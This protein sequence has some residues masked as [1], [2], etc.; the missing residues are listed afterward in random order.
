MDTSDRAPAG[1][2]N[3]TWEILMEKWMYLLP[4]GGAVL[5]LAAASLNL[6]TAL[7][8]RR[9]RSNEAGPTST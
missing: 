2:H 6:L 4:V 8:K 1:P 5:N 7:I 3:Y 9:S